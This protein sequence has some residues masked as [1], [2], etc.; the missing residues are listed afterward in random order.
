M[1]TA[2]VA[3]A[4]MALLAVPVLA[5]VT[6]DLRFVPDPLEPC[7]SHPDWDMIYPVTVTV[8]YN[9]RQDVCG[10]Q[11][12][13]DYMDSVHVIEES[14]E[15]GSGW[16]AND[17]SCSGTNEDWA[18]TI[19][20]DLCTFIGIADQEGKGLGDDNFGGQED[21]QN[22][23]EFKVWFEYPIYATCGDDFFLYSAYPLHNCKGGYTD[24]YVFGEI[25]V[26]IVDA[27][28]WPD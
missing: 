14:F 5:E 3:V 22:I 1:K 13:M 26:L 20:Y 11:I 18:G 12:W 15:P 2:I 8:Q 4:L 25:E 7:W 16:H 9:G 6:A 24:T 27:C 23:C 28:E 17:V 19:G 21:W 10:F